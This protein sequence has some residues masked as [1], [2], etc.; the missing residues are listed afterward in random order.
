MLLFI[1]NTFL[2]HAADSFLRS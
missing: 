2:L 1:L